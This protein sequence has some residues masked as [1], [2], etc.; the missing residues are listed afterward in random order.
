MVMEGEKRR[1]AAGVIVVVV[2]LRS[3]SKLIPPNDPLRLPVG[4]IESRGGGGSA[5]GK[6][7]KACKVGLDRIFTIDLQVVW[8]ITLY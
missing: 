5:G 1:C 8:V 7:G 6:N 3:S 2:A 4:C